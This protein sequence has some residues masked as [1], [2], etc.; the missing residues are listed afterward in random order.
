MKSINNKTFDN[1]RALYG[2]EDSLVKECRFEGKGD[3]ES[4]LK[5][6]R[7]LEVSNSF[8]ALRYPFWHCSTLKISNIEM[9]PT[10]RAAFWYCLDAEISS[11]TLHGIKALRECQRFSLNNCEIVSP[12]FGWRCKDISI[13]NVTL[14][15]EYSFFETKKIV[16]NN[17]T[18]EGKYSFQYV[19][20]ATFTNCV[21]NTKDA[22]WHS[23]GVVVK[24]SEVRGEYLG[25]YSE[26]LT[27]INCH[28]K[29]TQPLCYC[30]G[31]KLVNCTME[32]CDLSFEY[33]D[34]D[35]EIKGHIDS[36]K[37]P[38][39]GRIIADSIGEVIQKDSKYPLKA[40]IEI[41][42]S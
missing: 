27:L 12:E 23:K 8:F 5:E 28:I 38:I 24:D 40:H 19:E 6:S 37:N 39:N 36:I 11:S 35:A 14:K 16:A 3:G 17:L 33:S 20:E 32:D 41:R 13:N 18:F 25:W 9:T 42:K 22:F 2:L 34:V 15:S 1:E 7:N 4:A 26:G 30:Q 21:F 10:C 29:G 31:L